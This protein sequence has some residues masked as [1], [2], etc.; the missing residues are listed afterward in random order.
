MTL[1][2][3]VHL[4]KKKRQTWK[5]IKIKRAGE[6][7]VHGIAPTYAKA[8]IILEHHVCNNLSHISEL[9]LFLMAQSSSNVSQSKTNLVDQL[10]QP[11][12]INR[13]TSSLSICR[14]SPVINIL[15]FK[16]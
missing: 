14:L 4:N 2:V 5:T 7:T 12:W 16:K 3:E 6:F 11:W 8:Q 9:A 15:L 1:A 10:D 13:K